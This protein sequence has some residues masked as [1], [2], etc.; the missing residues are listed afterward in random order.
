MLP[1]AAVTPRGQVAWVRKN[2]GHIVPWR[3]PQG[4]SEKASASETTGTLTPGVEVDSL[5]WGWRR[6]SSGL[7]PGLLPPC[8]L[9]L[10]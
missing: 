7:C 9:V 4:S 3:P 1:G 2:L 8:P 10:S 6:G 5:R